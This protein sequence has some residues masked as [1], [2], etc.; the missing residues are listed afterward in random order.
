MPICF[1]RVRR[2][3]KNG[4]KRALSENAADNAWCSYDRLSTAVTEMRAD[5]SASVP[6]DELTAVNSDGGGGR[7]KIWLTL[8]FLQK[9]ENRR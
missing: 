2:L 6:L 5:A 1:E 4:L 8:K 7:V 9:L 3:R